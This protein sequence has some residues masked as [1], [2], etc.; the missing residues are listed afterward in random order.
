MR[1]FSTKPTNFGAC[2][3]TYYYINVLR[4]VSKKGLPPESSN[5]SMP[6]TCSWE[7]FTSLYSFAISTFFTGTGKPITGQ[8]TQASTVTSLLFSEPNAVFTAKHFIVYLYLSYPTETGK[9]GKR[10]YDRT[11]KSLC[12]LD[13]FLKCVKNNDN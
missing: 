9:E 2:V 6:T 10:S 8:S 13:L 1:S 7:Q 3:F 5:E 12:S 11:T 4:L